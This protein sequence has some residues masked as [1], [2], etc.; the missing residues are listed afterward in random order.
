M[1]E[2]YVSVY[3]VSFGTRV[4]MHRNGV[5]Y[6]AEYRGIKVTEDGICGHNVNTQHIFWLGN[7]QGE[8]EVA[9]NISIYTTVQDA[10]QERNAIALNKINIENFSK[11]YLLHLL[12]NGI[13]FSGW[14]WDGSR[15]IC[16]T[17]RERLKG[18][19]IH[20]GEIEFIDCQGNVYDANKFNRFY[21]TAEECRENNTPKIMMLDDEDDEA[22]TP[23]LQIAH[24]LSDFNPTDEAILYTK[25]YTGR[26]AKDICDY[27]ISLLDG[28]N[29]NLLPPTVLFGASP[30]VC[31]LFKDNDVWCGFDNRDQ[32][33]WVEEFK[34]E[35]QAVQWIYYGS[36]DD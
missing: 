28:N 27:G 24:L 10:T 32:D 6:Q 7:K 11:K 5:I 25:I 18:C 15:P 8:I 35:L 3:P 22:E 14:L 16:R 20:Q 13:Q 12:W 31:G 36:C 17:P 2:K 21:Q 29:D 9:S 33:C 1:T 19:V 4:F 23:Q 26:N 34:T 30:F